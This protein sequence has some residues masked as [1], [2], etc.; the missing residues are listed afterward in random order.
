MKRFGELPLAFVNNRGIQSCPAK[1][2]A[3]RRQF[4]HFEPV[5]GFD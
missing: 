4:R 2:G 3:I 5:P 1:Q